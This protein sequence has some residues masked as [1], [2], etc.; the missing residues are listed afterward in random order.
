ML[1]TVNQK[2]TVSCGDKTYLVCKMGVIKAP[3]TLRMVGL[4][5]RG[6]K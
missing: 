2:F 5:K 3:P 6:E 4:F 1:K